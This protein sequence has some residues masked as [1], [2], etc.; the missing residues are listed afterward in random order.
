[1]A[2]HSIRAYFADISPSIRLTHARLVL[3]ISPP[4]PSDMH[5]LPAFSSDAR[6][7]WTLH[8]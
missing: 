1:M 8:P 4:A 3:D 6:Y 2:Y 7:A 5:G